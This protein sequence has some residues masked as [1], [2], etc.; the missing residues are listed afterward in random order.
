ME[1]FIAWL[2]LHHPDQASHIIGSLVVDEHHLTDDQLLAKARD[3]YATAAKSE[4][5]HADHLEQ[6]RN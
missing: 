4:D 2:K 5:D 1:Q 3:F 6:R